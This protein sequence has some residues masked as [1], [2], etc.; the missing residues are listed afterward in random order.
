[1]LVFLIGNVHRVWCIV[2]H[3]D[4]TGQAYHC[5]CRT[6]PISILNMCLPPGGGGLHESTREDDSK[7][8]PREYQLRLNIHNTIL[9]KYNV[10]TVAYFV[11]ALGHG[12]FRLNVSFVH[13]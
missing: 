1:M 12:P 5:S 7:C 10:S 3:D 4:E 11:G 13:M 6:L 8:S 9:E 2:L